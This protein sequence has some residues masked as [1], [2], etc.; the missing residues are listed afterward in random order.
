VLKREKQEYQDRMAQLEEL[1]NIGS[2]RRSHRTI[3]KSIRD[4]GRSPSADASNHDTDSSD[5]EQE[6]KNSS[7]KHRSGVSPSAASRGTSKKRPWSSKR[8]QITP[9]PFSGDVNI[10][11]YLSQFESCAEWNGW[12]RSQKAQ[13]LFMCLRGRARGVSYLCV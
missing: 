9:E 8:K 11:E 6:R 3:T 5:E 10:K 1:V 2:S 4:R 7:G 12:T 13:Q